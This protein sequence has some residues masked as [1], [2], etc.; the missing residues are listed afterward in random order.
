[1]DNPIPALIFGGFL[2]ALGGF[3]L[4]NQKKLNDSLSKQD[5]PEQ[6]LKF[7][8]RRS[9]RRMQVAGLILLIGI[10]IPTGDSLIP[11][12]HALVT[13][14]IYWLIVLGLAFWIILLA[15]ADIVATRTHTSVELTRLQ[16][17]QQSL[18]Q[19]ANQLRKAQAAARR[20]SP[21]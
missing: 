6:E 13:F 8:R 15:L 4:F 20:D 10:M 16:I 18:E 5:L 14:A 2:I 19:A 3:L 1:M 12:G 7:L 11:W 17:Q 21:S 9:R